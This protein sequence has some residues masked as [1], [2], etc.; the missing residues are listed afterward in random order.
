MIIMSHDIEIVDGKACIAYAGETPWHGL[1]TPVSFDLSPKQMM[2]LAGL[3]WTVK[4]LA[5]TTEHKGKR[6][7]TGYKALVRESDSAV[8]TVTGEQWHPIQNIEA[9]EFFTDFV[10]AGDMKMHTAGSL[11]GGRMVWALAKMSEGFALFKGKDEVETNVLFYNPHEYGKTAGAMLTPTRVVCANTLAMAMSAGSGILKTALDTKTRVRITH[12]KKFDPE[13]VKMA[14]GLARKQ[15][16]EYKHKAE[17]LASRRYTEDTLQD[18][19]MGVF[20]SA[21]GSKKTAE[22][23]FSQMAAL[24]ASVMETQPGADF[25]AGSFWQA[26]N[27]TTFVMDHLACRPDKNGEGQQDRRLT[28]S[29]FGWF[30]RRK[31]LALDLAVEMADKAPSVRAAA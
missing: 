7:N 3:D 17:L 6:I 27:A 22:R 23:E 31:L 14:M 4:K 26:F 9:F 8:F 18:Y 30:Q 5:C 15:V 10:N 24:A 11:K 19:F 20:P 2:E 16:A 21:R 12:R 28:S 25:G 13:E 1:G 29:W